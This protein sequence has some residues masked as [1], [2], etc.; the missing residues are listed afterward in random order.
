METK[1]ENSWINAENSTLNK[2]FLEGIKLSNKQRK[3]PKPEEPEFLD[4]KTYSEA[5]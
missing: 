1:E 4:C 5:Q 2:E 3:C